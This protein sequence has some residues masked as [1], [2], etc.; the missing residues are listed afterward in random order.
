MSEIRLARALSLLSNRASDASFKIGL[1]AIAR[2]TGRLL[3]TATTE[4]EGEGIAFEPGDLLFGKLRP[5]LAKTWLADRTGAAVGDFLVLKP[6]KI[7]DAGY[8]QY[9]LLSD[10]FL[11]P[12]TATTT[13]AK[14]PRTDWS[15]IKNMAVYVP[16]LDEQRVIADY[17]DQETAQIDALVA[18]Q[19]EFIGLLRERRT[20]AVAAIIDR[21]GS[22]QV[23]RDKLHRHVRM[24]NGS[25]PRSGESR[26]YDGGSIPWV[27]SSVV[28]QQEVH[29]PSKLVTLAA[30]AECHLPMVK[31][32]SILVALTGQGKTRGAATISRIST[33]I[34]QHLAF[35]EPDIRYW[36][37]EYL[38]SLL[39]S[40]YDHLR[41]ISSEN[42][43]TKGGLTVGDLRALPVI[44]PRREVQTKAVE[45]IDSAVSRIDVLIAKAE[46]HIALA[47][48]RRSALIT[49]AVTGQVDVRTAKKGAR[50]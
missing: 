44:M 34:N 21:E 29:Q 49:A 32:G 1:D 35:I 15:T 25:T 26:Y 8:L 46:E 39:H 50:V 22:E 3:A 17:L 10:A 2:S 24:G 30:V 6:K 19:E 36:V 13:G 33:T 7:A 37:P 42:G 31:P 4:F 47:K 11:E 43:A 40:K 48:E 38:L 18:K 20:A 23:R 5:Y 28:N 14:M 12:V 9:V 27:N 16:P 45:E 41:R